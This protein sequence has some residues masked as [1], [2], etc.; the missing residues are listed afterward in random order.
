M[1]DLHKFAATYQ[2]DIHVVGTVTIGDEGDGAS[3]GRKRRLRLYAG[4]LVTGLKCISGRAEA[5][6]TAHQVT[7]EASTAPA[8]NPP[9]AHAAG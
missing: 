6:C 9:M 1:R 4:E 5:C 3:V 2:A 7:A 8:R